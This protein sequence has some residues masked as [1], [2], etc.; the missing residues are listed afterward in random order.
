MVLWNGRNGHELAR[1]EV[2]ANQGR[3]FG[4][5]PEPAIRD[6]L[7]RTGDSL[8]TSMVEQLFH[9]PE[10]DLKLVVRHLPDVAAYQQLV[11]R[12]RAMPRV[13]QVKADALGF[14]RGKSVLLV[15]FAGRADLFGS[16]LD[17][18]TDFDYQGREGHVLNCRISNREF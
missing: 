15:R 12:L 13:R 5:T 3:G 9:P 4:N 2:E 6:S 17:I 10:I 8:A 7:R 11:A 18:M 16:M 14:H 1:A